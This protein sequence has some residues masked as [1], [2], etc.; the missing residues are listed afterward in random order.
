MRRG[1]VLCSLCLVTALGGV[2]MAQRG[3]VVDP[4]QSGLPLPGLPGTDGPADVPASAEQKRSRV[5][6]GTRNSAARSSWTST[7]VSSTEIVEPWS[8]EARGADPRTP[9][10]A[11]VPGPVEPAG[12]WV[13]PIAEIVDPWP[14]RVSWAVEY[15]WIIDPWR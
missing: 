6:P 13:Q 8:D 9:A 15:T 4:W 5:P 3:V 14:G 10:L 2:A 7:I 12:S 1:I 11:A